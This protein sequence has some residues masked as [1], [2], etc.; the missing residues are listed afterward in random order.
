ML[1]ASTRHDFPLALR[2]L[3]VEQ[4]VKFEGPVVEKAFIDD[5]N[6]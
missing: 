5:L 4:K 3:S 2:T 6:R 1:I